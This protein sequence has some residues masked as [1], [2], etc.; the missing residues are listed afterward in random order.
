MP[1]LTSWD[2]VGS[3]GAPQAHNS[4]PFEE[5]GSL[6]LVASFWGVAGTQARHKARTTPTAFY[7]HTF[8]ADSECED[9]DATFGRVLSDRNSSLGAN[10]TMAQQT[11][12]GGASSTPPKSQGQEQHGC[13]AVPLSIA[14]RRRVVTRECPLA[15]MIGGIEADEDDCGVADHPDG[16]DTIAELR[17]RSVGNMDTLLTGEIG[18]Y[19]GAQFEYDTYS[20]AAPYVHLHFVA[21]DNVWL[22]RVR[23]YLQEAGGDYR[24]AIQGLRY[25]TA[26]GHVAGSLD[27]V[28][29]WLE[30]TPLSVDLSCVNL[31]SLGRSALGDMR[32]WDAVRADAAVTE[33]PG[34]VMIV[35]VW[36]MSSRHRNRLMHALNGN[37]TVIHP[38]GKSESWINDLPDSNFYSVLSTVRGLSARDLD[39]VEDERSAGDDGSDDGDFMGAEPNVEAGDEDA[40]EE[41]AVEHTTHLP[42]AQCAEVVRPYVQWFSK[43]HKGIQAEPALKAARDWNRLHALID[44]A[45]PRDKALDHGPRVDCWKPDSKGGKKPA[46]KKK[47]E[48]GEKSGAQKTRDAQRMRQW[49]EDVNPEIAEAW[50]RARR[51]DPAQVSQNTEYLSSYAH[52]RVRSEVYA[53]G[54]EEPDLF[55]LPSYVAD[56]QTGRTA[57]MGPMT[58][59]LIQQLLM[60]GNIELQPGPTPTLSA[61]NYELVPDVDEAYRAGVLFVLSHHADTCS[62]YGHALSNALFCAVSQPLVN[63]V[64]AVNHANVYC[65]QPGAHPGDWSVV[66]TWPDGKSDKFGKSYRRYWDGYE[67]AVEACSKSGVVSYHRDLETLYSTCTLEGRLTPRTPTGERIESC[68]VHV[69]RNVPSIVV[70][71]RPIRSRIILMGGIVVRIFRGCNVSALH[72]TGPQPMDEF[73]PTPV[74]REVEQTWAGIG[75]SQNAATASVSIM[76][77]GGVNGALIGVLNAALAKDMLGSA[78]LTASST[79]AYRMRVITDARN[80]QGRMR[81][82]QYVVGRNEAQPDYATFMRQEAPPWPVVWA[83][84]ATCLAVGGVAVYTAWH[85]GLWLTEAVGRRSLDVFQEYRLVA[86]AR[87]DAAAVAARDAL[88]YSNLQVRLIGDNSLV[89]ALVTAGDQRLAEA[90]DRAV[91]T[92]GPSSWAS[93]A[94][95][96]VINAM[97]SS[98]RRVVRR[99]V[100]PS[101]LA[102]DFSAHSYDNFSAVTTASLFEEESAGA[103][104]CRRWLTALAS[105][106]MRCNVLPLLEECFKRYCGWPGVMAIVAVETWND[107]ATGGSLFGSL[108]YRASAHSLLQCLNPVAAYF[109]HSSVNLVSFLS[110]FAGIPMLA[111]PWYS[112]A[113]A[114]GYCVVQKGLVWWKSDG[115]GRHSNDH[116][117]FQ[118]GLTPELDPL[119]RLTLVR[120]RLG[121][122]PVSAASVV[123]LFPSILDMASYYAGLGN[124]CHSARGRVGQET[125]QITDF[126]TMGAVHSALTR[127]AKAALTDHGVLVP[128]DFDEFVSKFPPA[129]RAA[130][131]QAKAEFDTSGTQPIRKPELFKDFRARECACF[132]K[133]EL[134]VERPDVITVHDDF[135][136]RRVA[137]VP[138]TICPRWLPLQAAL[139]PWI[140]SADE[141]IKRTLVERSRELFGVEVRFASGLNPEQMSAMCHEL[142]VESGVDVVIVNGDD[143]MFVHNG[144]AYYVDGERWDAHFRAEHHHAIIDAYRLMGIP[145]DLIEAMHILVKR[146]LNWGDGL[147]ATIY[148]NNASGESDT[149]LRNGLCNFAVILCCMMGAGDFEAFLVKAKSV[150]FVYTKEAAQRVVTDPFGDFCARVWFWTFFGPALVLKPGRLL[151]KLCWTT[152]PGI[153]IVEVASA[154]ADAVARDL[155]CFPELAAEVRKLAVAP[156]P[157]AVEWVKAQRYSYSGSCAAVGTLADREE[158][159]ATRYGVEYSAVVDGLKRFVADHRAGLPVA[160]SEVLKLVAMRDMGVHTCRHEC[161]RSGAKQIVFEHSSEGAVEREASSGYAAWLQANLG[162]MMHMLNGNGRVTVHSLFGDGCHS[163][164]LFGPAMAGQHVRLRSPRVSWLTAAYWALGSAGKHVRLR[165]P[166]VSW[167]AATFLVQVLVLLIDFCVRDGLWV[168]RVSPSMGGGYVLGGRVAGILIP[169]QTLSYQRQSQMNQQPK[170]RPRSAPAPQRPLVVMQQVKKPKHKNAQA[171]QLTRSLKELN[172]SRNARVSVPKSISEFDI[173]TTRWRRSLLEPFKYPGCVAAG[174][175]FVR[176]AVPYTLKRTLQLGT[177]AG[178]SAGSVVICPSLN[179]M[180]FNPDGALTFGGADTGYYLY[181]ETTTLPSVNAGSSVVPLTGDKLTLPCVGLSLGQLGSIFERYRIVSMGIRLKNDASFSNTSGKLVTVC[182]PYEGYLPCG[183]YN[184]GNSGVQLNTPY[185]SGNAFADGSNTLYCSHPDSTLANRRHTVGAFLADVGVKVDVA[186]VGYNQPFIPTSALYGQPLAEA[187]TINE[188]GSKVME[189]AP[190]PCSADLWRWKDCGNPQLA[191]NVGKSGELTVL[192]AGT[193]S[194]PGAYLAYAQSGIQTLGNMI[195]VPLDVDA[196]VFRAS[197]FETTIINFDGVVTGGNFAELDIVYNIE[198]IPASNSGTSLPGLTPSVAAAAVGRVPRG[199]HSAAVDML[200]EVSAKPPVQIVEVAS[201]IAGSLIGGGAGAAVT[202]AGS[203]LAGG[204]AGAR[205]GH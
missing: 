171:K 204:R 153:P 195:S 102:F 175:F 172:V 121:L 103:L 80:G 69:F 79:A 156:T 124:R 161:D 189:I 149:T 194:F 162:W 34:S 95:R 122:C 81:F 21:S 168:N 15:D 76:R 196:S 147:R 136:W 152:M 191:T 107:L 68:S 88:A 177:A 89:N 186:T 66:I 72:V 142:M 57:Y 38:S 145:D 125:A 126:T 47:G 31:I 86:Q 131:V 113:L 52:R 128:K 59:G 160:T 36:G 179:C 100:P 4:P 173:A 43:A 9:L 11:D 146:E 24:A 29:S 139:L 132:L 111:A 41:V 120:K 73:I 141:V 19:D 27:D 10:A 155:V 58:R 193:D 182:L 165:S 63:G 26:T 101:L 106:L 114:A 150:G 199:S 183:T 2:H 109:A 61:N 148:R 176:N 7:Y 127:L 110:P 170:N 78:A 202:L 151:A 77:S 201:T 185:T 164:A 138:R 180:A 18:W 158:F 154:K 33:G 39:V 71:P 192:N 143:G 54:V 123:R 184:I 112:H 118:R 3:P 85:R 65:G 133:H 140:L 84:R 75:T 23:T 169:E 1:R 51:P 60:I 64:P 45:G 22:P 130:Y 55:L 200:H 129:K 28:L 50:V 40:E 14:E 157:R 37:T 137:G 203:L 174:D 190:R 32:A 188:L 90:C 13:C 8:A 134:N 97:R 96:S 181:A 115:M 187:C 82:W 70:I 144:I 12:N 117:A 163:P 20:L 93:R 105:G 42:D 135:T 67:W 83:A 17:L 62:T 197:G 91:E 49:M 53:K 205:F 48:K 119:M 178:K 167:L 94:S 108:A 74:L 35:Y 5:P 98:L 198:A 6:R 56:V 30:D 116:E 92:A 104:Y 25:D 99:D 16:F 44:C 159:F 166:R 46:D 87:I